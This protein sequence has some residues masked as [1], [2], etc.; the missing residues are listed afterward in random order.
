MHGLIRLGLATISLYHRTRI[1]AYVGLVLSLGIADLIL[2]S[3][4]VQE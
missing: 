4:L 3:F 2:F 1:N